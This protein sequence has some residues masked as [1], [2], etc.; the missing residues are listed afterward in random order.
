MGYRSEVGLALTKKGVENLKQRLANPELSQEIREVVREFFDCA[1]K[2]AKDEEDGQE[3]WY[4]DY[5][6]WYMGF[7]EVDFIEQLLS[8]LPDEDFRFIR[9][10]EDYDD[11]EMR[12]GFWDDPFG[13]ELTRSITF[14]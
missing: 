13:M 7:P 5:R 12:G 1:D 11:T 9:I 4:W 2:H 8:E 6:K 10:G 14:A 3:A